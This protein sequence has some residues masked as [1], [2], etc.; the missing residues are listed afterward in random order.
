MSATLVKPTE[1]SFTWL[2]CQEVSQTKFNSK[3]ETACVA[4]WVEDTSNTCYVF[5]HV[6]ISLSPG[7]STHTASFRFLSGA[8]M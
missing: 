3:V 6:L 5:V 8:V 1:Q 7:D 2:I 4:S